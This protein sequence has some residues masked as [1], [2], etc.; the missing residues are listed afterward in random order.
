MKYFEVA[1]TSDKN[2]RIQE[3]QSLLDAS[4]AADIP[5]FH[6]CGGNA[7]C[8]TCRVLVLAGKELLTPP[9]EKEILLKEQMHFSDNIRLACQ[10]YVNGNGV[11]LTRII[12]DE[13]DIALYVGA[14]AADFTEN[15]GIEKKVVLCFIDIRSFTH[16]V[17]THLPFDIIHI[18]RKLFN[19][20][21]AII[22][23]NNGKIIET[24][25]DG[26]YAVFGLD[27][28]IGQSADAAVRSGY[29][30]LKS[31]EQ[32]NNEYFS[33]H[34]GQKIEIG[35][36]VHA[37]IVVAGNVRLGNEKH[38]LVMGYPVNVASRLQN[39]T[40]E[41]NNNFIIS[42]EAFKLTGAPMSDHPSGIIQLKG[43]A[44]PVSIHLLGSPYENGLSADA[45][46][47]SKHL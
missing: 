43:I 25:G 42:T 15:I 2:I 40:K 26:L 38:L 14:T 39:A 47:N 12:R 19:C 9:N 46:S 17:E 6:V 32:L 41:L 18:M 22:E 24:T 34:F 10:T 44:E 13:S 31:L 36:G 35:I 45:T 29:D 11:R 33:K 3:D 21:H 1:F 27:K 5:H 7:R 8:S 20:F 16:F 30:I 23:K 28:S 4:I 37:G